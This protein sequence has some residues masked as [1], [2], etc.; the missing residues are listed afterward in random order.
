V[1]DEQQSVVAHGRPGAAWRAAL[2]DRSLLAYA[3]LAI[4]LSWGLWVPAALAGGQL[5]H[6]PG[7]LGPL[8][9]GLVVTGWT[10]GSDGLREL[11][12]RLVLWRTSPRWYAVAAVPFA[13]AAV[14]VLLAGAIG[15]RPDLADFTVM[16]GLPDL[17]WPAMAALL[18]VLNGY[19]EEGGWRG[20]AWPRL[21]AYL[22]LRDAALLLT[23]GWA[24]WHA[25][26]LFLDSGLTDL[27]LLVLPG[28]LIGL[29]SGAVV[30]GWLYER[31]GSVL[32]VALAHTALNLVSGTRG[33]EGLVAATASATVIIG[34]VLV[35]R[36][37]AARDRQAD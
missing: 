14:G 4:V 25:P 5:S 24:L 22:G 28:W 15:R 37:E 34:A 20:F 16:P 13:A 6:F 1:G 29:A 3:G 17:P 21:R 27:P 19:G 23:A 33:G 10:R 7:L 36:A 12:A 11:A 8:L 2:Q 30:L 32:V 18:L 9:A 35:L 26:L 31:S